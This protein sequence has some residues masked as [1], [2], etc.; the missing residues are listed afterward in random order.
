MDEVGEA[1][2]VSVGLDAAKLDDGLDTLLAPA[3]A[4]VV[5]ALGDDVLDRTFDR[6]GAEFEPL[7]D[8]EVVAEE[9]H[10][11]ADVADHLEETLALPLVAG[12]GLGRLAPSPP[13]VG[14]DPPG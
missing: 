13:E 3:H 2:E 11:L 6:S 8:Q 4:A 1:V 7:L 14:D 5:A 12:A 10:A 9:G